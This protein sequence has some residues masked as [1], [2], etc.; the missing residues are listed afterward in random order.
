MRYGSPSR[1]ARLIALVAILAAAAPAEAQLISPGKLS[2]PHSG[3]E[4]IRNCTQCHQLGRRGVSRDLCLDCHQPLAARLEREQGFHATLAEPD[5]ASCHKDHFGADFALVKL[6]TLAFDHERTGHPLE[7]AHEVVDCRSCHTPTRIAD[8]AVR[9]VKG[10]RG[11]LERTFLGLATGCDDCHATDDPHVDTFA[12]QPCTDCH[13]QDTWDGAPGFD[14]A[15]TRYPLTGRHRGADCRGCHTDLPADV[16]SGPWPRGEALRFDGLR[17]EGCATCHADPH[18]GAMDDRC[19]SC[20]DT[21]D[22]LGVDRE[23]V[24]SRFDHAST[25]FDLVG[26][27]EAMECADCHDAQRVAGLSGIAM[28]FDSSTRDHAFP[29]PVA[30][31]CATCHTDPHDGL[32]EDLPAG[33]VCTDCHGEV[34]WLPASYDLARHNR[35]AAF[36]LEGAHAVIPC[37]TCHESSDGRLEFALGVP[38][39]CVSCHEADDPHG[40]QFVGRGCDGCHGIDSFLPVAVDH[41]ATR[42]PLD[43]GHTALDCADCHRTE[44]NDRGGVMTLYR[45]LGTDCRDCHGGTS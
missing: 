12:D 5:C 22:W 21:R 33:G 32:F 34:N 2:A 31:T 3:L 15:E 42:F 39:N 27:H 19:Q 13:T 16:E 8:P 7:G 37:A 18:D 28:T 9:Q 44:P 17:V 26:R 11:A 25:G 43:G 45:P 41:D 35:E 23:R 40:G 4:G 14:H 30:G 1:V 38:E 29:R 24:A 36:V 6:D 10:D 20:H